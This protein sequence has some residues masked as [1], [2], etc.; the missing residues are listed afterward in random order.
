MDQGP[1]PVVNSCP[2]SLTWIEIRLVDME[3]NPVPN[4]KYRIQKP[5]NLFR[6]FVDSAGKARVKVSSLESAWFASPS[7]TRKR[8]NAFED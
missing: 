3:G 6:P 2:L 7:L 8:G 5:D 1:K 4:K